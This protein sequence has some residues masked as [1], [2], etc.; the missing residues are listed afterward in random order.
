MKNK[1]GRLLLLLMAILTAATANA[2][3]LQDVVY[4][5]NG[6]VVRG[7]LIEQVPKVKIRTSD[8]SLWVFDNNEIDK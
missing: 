3:Q 8:G 2:Q 4:L 1:I 6:S 5:T 7:T